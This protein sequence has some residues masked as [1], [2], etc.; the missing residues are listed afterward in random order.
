MVVDTIPP[1][2]SSAPLEPESTADPAVTSPVVIIVGA[3]GLRNSD[4]LPGTGKPDC[5][6]QVKSKDKL[7]HT[8]AV[9]NNTCEPVWMEKQPLAELEGEAPLEFSVYDKDLVGSDFLGTATLEAR[10]FASEG[11]NGELQLQ[12]AKVPQAYLRVKVKMPGK[13]LPRGPLAEYTVTLE[14]ASANDSYSVRL[15]KMDHRR[16]S[17]LEIK[18]GPFTKY[19]ASAKPEQQIRVHDF[20]VAVNSAK[21]D[22]AAMLSEFGSSLQVECKIKRGM[23]VN[24]IF[25]RGDKSMAL[26]LEMPEQP[27]GMVTGLVHK[28]IGGGAVAKHNAAAK[29]HEKINTGD[30]ILAVGSTRGKAVDIQRALENVTGQ[31]QLTLVK[32]AV[33]RNEEGDSCTW[34]HWL[35][36]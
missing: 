35:F 18:D 19:N 15:D 2:E 7:L 29:E 23:P 3:R 20:I 14:R 24:V 13:D 5:Y 1:A 27:T 21:E 31:V 16:L 12:K 28:V 25:D 10:D 4:W 17:I 33:S 22:V 9:I 11:F 34:Q 30:R 36:G 26:G 32:P 6:V 8:T